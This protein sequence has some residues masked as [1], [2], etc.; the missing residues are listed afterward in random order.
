MVSK[1]T[2]CRQQ[3]G[4]GDAYSTCRA[5]NTEKTGPSRMFAVDSGPFDVKTSH[6]IQLTTGV[7]TGVG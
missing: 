2:I 1:N 4:P 3:R 5:E 7:E 6:R